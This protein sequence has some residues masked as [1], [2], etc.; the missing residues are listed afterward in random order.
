MI[1]ELISHQKL[2]KKQRPLCYSQAGHLLALEKLHLY[3]MS[4]P[5]NTN[6]EN[7]SP[8]PKQQPDKIIK[9]VLICLSHS[10]LV[11]GSN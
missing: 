5:S 3:W 8:K 2:K 9:Y 7:S 6:S 1:F 4:S 11:L 10:F